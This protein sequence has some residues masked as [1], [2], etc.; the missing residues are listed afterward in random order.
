MRVRSSELRSSA[1]ADEPTPVDPSMTINKEYQKSPDLRRAAAEIP[2]RGG[3]RNAIV[4]ADD[5]E[6]PAYQACRDAAGSQASSNCRAG[7]TIS[8]SS[9]TA[10]SPRS[11]PTK[12]IRSRLV[13]GNAETAL[14][15]RI[16][17]RE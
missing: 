8:H 14:D 12:P 1:C 7:A 15:A 5:W 4:E 17:R 6:G 9:I 13:R 10:K 16:A 2:R 11:R 3:E